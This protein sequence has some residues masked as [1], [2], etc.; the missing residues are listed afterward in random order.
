[1]YIAFI[2]LVL[3]VAANLL[4]IPRYGFMGAAWCTLGTELIVAVLAVRIL[5]HELSIERIPFGRLPRIVAAAV[6][7]GVLLEGCEALGFP[8][9]AI[10]VVAVAVYPAL[11]F[12]LRAL[13]ISEVTDLLLR[14]QPAM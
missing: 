11:L 2:G 9:G 7:F 8:L 13:R 6:A 10:C 3:N 1:M 4:L 12:G 14:R 5:L